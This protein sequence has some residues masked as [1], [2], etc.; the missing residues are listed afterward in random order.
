LQATLKLACSFTRVVLLLFI[1]ISWRR[2]SLQSLHL[3]LGDS[4]NQAMGLVL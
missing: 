1:S 4:I 2:T 3:Q